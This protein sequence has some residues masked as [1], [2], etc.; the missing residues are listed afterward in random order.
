MESFLKL[1]EVPINFLRKR[2]NVSPR[3]L[4][5]MDLTG[6]YPEEWRGISFSTIFLT[7][8][9]NQI[10]RG[11]FKFEAI[12]KAKL[13]DLFSHIFE[14]DGEGEGVMRMEIRKGFRDWLGS[15]EDDENRRQDLLAFQ[16]F[17]LD[18]F[19]E[20]YKRIPPEEEIDPR[21]VRGLLIR[22]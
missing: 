9:A 21:F 10:L 6:C 15:M 16:D 17:C 12:E 13:K 18:L 4:R 1:I 20:E 7:A 19:E 5:E 2:L 14:K 8:L 22:I 3:S 11:T